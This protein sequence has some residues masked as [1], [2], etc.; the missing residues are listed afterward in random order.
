MTKKQ[1]RVAKVVRVES[2]RRMAQDTKMAPKP[3]PDG[4]FRFENQGM[5]NAFAKAYMCLRCKTK[6]TR[7]GECL[8]YGVWE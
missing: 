5:V 3:A 7:H 8:C 4:G 6:F 1:V 2:L